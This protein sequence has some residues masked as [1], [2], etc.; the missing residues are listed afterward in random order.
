MLLDKLTGSFYACNKYFEVYL[1][2]I[3]LSI[4]IAFSF[5]TCED[6]T[7]LT[8]ELDTIVVSP[9]RSILQL[10]QTVQFNALAI[11]KSNSSMDIPV[12]W[13]TTN[14]QIATITK[15]GLVTAVG[16]GEANIYATV[17]NIQ[18]MAEV[19][20]STDRRRVLSEMFTSS[21]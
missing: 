14:D 17:D 10:G 7:Q 16:Q 11:D 1:K 3:F 12:T 21:T 6:K 9:V 18:G 2:K 19:L 15:E 4:V 8:Q 5:W 13:S 20:V